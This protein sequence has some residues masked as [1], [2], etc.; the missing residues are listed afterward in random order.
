M[1]TAGNE[2]TRRVC[3]ATLIHSDILISAAHCFG[4]F[5][6]GLLAYDPSTN[7]FTQRMSIDRQQRHFIWD[8]NAKAWNYDFVVMRLS[9][10][11]DGNDA[12]KPIAV[13]TNNDYPLDSDR[14]QLY[15]F[16]VTEP[17][18]LSSS[19]YLRQVEMKYIENKV[20]GSRMQEFGGVSS[21]NLSN[22][23]LC[24]STDLP[25]VGAASACSG[26]SGG[27]VT[28]FDGTLLVGVIS[29]GIGCSAD[30]FPNV[31]AR[32]SVASGWIQEQICLLSKDPPSNCSATIVDDSAVE[33]A[34]V[35][36]HD[37]YADETTYAIRSKDD[38]SIVYS[39]PTYVPA[40]NGRFRSQIFLPPGEY[41]FEVYD[42]RGNGLRGMGAGDGDGWWKLYAMYDGET[43]TELAS[44]NHQFT[45]EQI[46]EFVIKDASSFGSQLHADEFYS[47]E[48]MENCLAIKAQEETYG[49]RFGTVCECTPSGDDSQNRVQL[50]CFDS[51]GKNGDQQQRSCAI[52][53]APCSSSAECC[54]G[55]RCTS[56]ICRS[57][58][59][60]P[61]SKE[62]FGLGRDRIPRPRSRSNDGYRRRQEQQVRGV[63]R[64]QDS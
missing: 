45:T 14:L 19:S 9:N 32:V 47:Y 10:P 36:V 44:G 24:T 2:W 53:Y 15:G 50:S 48:Q 16:G 41:S 4:S 59:S 22:E 34:L 54:S 26:D 13:N 11:I 23:F 5:N 60:T 62:D 40:R 39:G 18:G 37:F 1:V 43:D 29:F 28:N 35:F 58:E 52:N 42:S 55:R 56:G 6:Y 7:D 46:T 8:Y 64:P 3:G 17:G 12:V 20:C 57:S 38:D 33:L 61:S 31:N 25:G 30:T 21:P 27:P 49:T 63:S 51:P